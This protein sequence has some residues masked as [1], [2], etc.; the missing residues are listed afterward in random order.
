MT[1]FNWKIAGKAGEGIMII[2]KIFAR[3]C[4][5]VGFQVFNYYEYPS[6]IK[7]G[8]Q[9][10][11]VYASEINAS[12]HK[13][14]LDILLVL[15][16]E[17]IK[18]HQQEINENTIIIGEFAFKEN[19]LDSYQGIKAKFLN[20]PLKKLALEHTGN[21]ISVNA[22]A[23]GISLCFLGIDFLK[24]DLKEIIKAE[25][26]DKKQQV[27]NNVT[28]AFQVGFN[29]AAQNKSKVITPAVLKKKNK[30]LLLTGNE[31]VGMGAVA[32]GLQYYAAYPMTPASALL[33]FL[34][35]QQ[36]NYPLVVKHTEDEIAAINQVIGASFAGVRAM[37]G[38]SGGGFALMVEALSLS[39]VAEIP[40]V[41]LEAQ[42]PGPGT[43]L[44]T[45]T[46]QADLQFILRAGHGEFLRVVFTPATVAEHF[47]LTIKAFYLAEKYQIPVLILSDKYI[48]ESHQ[49]M[50]IPK[51]EYQNERQSLIDGQELNAKEEYLRYRQ[52]KTGIS[53]RSVPGQANALQLTNS[54]E[55]DNFG[56]ATEDTKMVEQQIKKRMKKLQGLRKEL[57]LPV[58]IGQAKA[59]FTFVSWG[60][61]TNV[62]Q[63]A[64][65]R[66]KKLNAIHLPCLWPFPK[67]EFLKLARKAKKLIMIEGNVTGQ[68]EQLI[69]Q[70]TDIKFD[71]NLRRY[72]GRP[73]CWEEIVDYVVEKSKKN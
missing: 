64:V 39:G 2:S 68:A 30:T 71:D 16:E 58:L 33:H 49:T 13:R 44:P 65:L 38:S 34:A 32:A 9:T 45:W 14:D 27:I 43:G 19:S 25:F 22:V 46:S 48:L 23:A 15:N 36:K 1:S 73:F 63:E 51:K 24:K 20:F 8:H 60:S 61:S 42:R 18:I 26:K 35:D 56:F 47:E 52:T 55:H 28:K 21:K 3:V 69:R 29:Y 70:E 41:I 54:Y 12:C 4:Q 7:G 37:T 57:P 67:K 62:L 40:V 72:D 50:P 17:S 6:L 11:Q 5:R 53:K 59:E 31:A 66:S 10:G